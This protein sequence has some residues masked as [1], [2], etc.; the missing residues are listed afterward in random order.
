[1][2]QE[3]RIRW[4]EFLMDQDGEFSF[5]RVF[6]AVFGAM[7]IFYFFVNLFTGRVVHEE[8]LDVMSYVIL[9]SIITVGVEP[10]SRFRRTTVVSKDAVITQEA[11]PVIQTAV[12]QSV[13]SVVQQVVSNSVI[14][15]ED[16]EPPK[17]KAEEGKET[18]PELLE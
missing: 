9:A 8:I 4:N 5:K 6:T 7:F 12:S 10:F 14:A 18:M 15:E 16:Q 3:R 11:N 17:K 13:E 1:M 2:A